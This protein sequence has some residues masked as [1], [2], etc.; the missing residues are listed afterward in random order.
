MSIVRGPGRRFGVGDRPDRTDDAGVVEHHVE[1][2][3]RRGRQIDGGGDRRLVG[4]IALRKARGV[5]EFAHDLLAE[6]GL[7]VGDHDL[8]PLLDEPP[9][10]RRADATRCAG[11]DGNLSGQPIA[12][13]PSPWIICAMVSW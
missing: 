5:A 3:P 4:H 1:P 8:G 7:D 2:A 13:Q 11:D 6:V 10:A 9:R 12:H